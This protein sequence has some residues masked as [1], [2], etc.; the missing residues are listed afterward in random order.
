MFGV[1]S[2]FLQTSAKHCANPGPRAG[3]LKHGRCHKQGM[4]RGTACETWVS[5]QQHIIHS[6][7]PPTPQAADVTRAQ[8]MYVTGLCSLPSKCCE[9]DEPASKNL[10]SLPSMKAE[11]LEHWE[12]LEWPTVRVKHGC[13]QLDQQRKTLAMR[14]STLL[15]EAL[16]LMTTARPNT[17]GLPR[18]LT[19][20]EEWCAH[21]QVK[22][23]AL[24]PI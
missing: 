20:V 12:S 14:P 17:H 5:E 16:I 24:E 8:S 21:C 13:E 23:Q 9:G 19:A 10:K 11:S 22:H 15:L 2:P 4:P 18:S 1:F 6:D 3:G 7:P